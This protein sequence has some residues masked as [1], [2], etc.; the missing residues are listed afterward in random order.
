[1][2]TRLN[3]TLTNF[4]F[5]TNTFHSF[6]YSRILSATVIHIQNNFQFSFVYFRSKS[7]LV[8]IF[9]LKICQLAFILVKKFVCKY[10]K[11]FFLKCFNQK[12]FQKNASN[13]LLVFLISFFRILVGLLSCRV[14]Y[15]NSCSG[16]LF[17][18]CMF[19]NDR[20]YGL[21][22]AAGEFPV[23]IATKEMRAQRLP[24]AH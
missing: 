19:G 5:S 1:M 15:V 18:L 3:C 23:A 9:F 4:L 21:G 14:N 12:Y 8:S 13:S 6:P 7:F 11:I 2:N 16:F 17:F 20:G 24:E 10:N 22:R